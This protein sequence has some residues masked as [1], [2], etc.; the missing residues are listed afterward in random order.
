MHHEHQ[1]IRDVMT[2][3]PTAIEPSTPLVEAARLMRDQDV[4]PLPIVEGERVV[5]MLTDRDIVVRAIAEG[6]DPQSVTA[7][8]VASKQLVT[9]DPEQPLD[10]AARLMAQHQVRRLPVCE[11]DGRLVGIVA[12]ADVAIEA[13][14]EK[15]GH[16]V[17]EISK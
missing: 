17:G 6:R 12:Q 9:I 10:E 16:V 4:G 5:G 8:E 14:A 2:P 13:P 11:E 1:K 7:H 3:D 15:A